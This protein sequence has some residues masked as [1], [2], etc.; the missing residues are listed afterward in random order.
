[1]A[2]DKDDEGG[3]CPG[4]DVLRLGPE[5]GN[6][7]HPFVRHRQGCRVEAGVL[8]THKPGNDEAMPPCDGIVRLSKTDGPDFDV[9]TLYERGQE[10]S[11]DRSGP[12]KVVS[13]AYRSGW[14]SI[15]GS[16]STVGQA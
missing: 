3:G 2:D 14:D 16:K 12:A 6:G 7:Y 15:F 8:K 9:E 4:R 1:M 11:A 5:I 13:N 10:S